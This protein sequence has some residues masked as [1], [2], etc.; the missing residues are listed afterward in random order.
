MSDKLSDIGTQYD[1]DS[2][3]DSSLS[4]FR[5]PDSKHDI[6]DSIE[7]AKGQDFHSTGDLYNPMCKPKWRPLTTSTSS[8]FSIPS[9]VLIPDTA[10]CE[11]AEENDGYDSESSADR[12]IITSS[13]LRRRRHKE[14][15]HRPPV[16]RLQSLDGEVYSPSL[17]SSDSEDNEKRFHSCNFCPKGYTVAK[18]H[19]TAKNIN[20]QPDSK[21]DK[22]TCLPFHPAYLDILAINASREPYVVNSLTTGGAKDRS[23]PSQASEEQRG[24]TTDIITAV[25]SEDKT[26][27]TPRDPSTT[28][29][30]PSSVTPGESEK[31]TVSAG[32]SRSASQKGKQLLRSNPSMGSRGDSYRQSSQET[33]MI[34]V[35]SVNSSGNLYFPKRT[36]GQTNNDSDSITSVKPQ[37]VERPSIDSNYLYQAEEDI[38]FFSIYKDI[39]VLQL[40]NKPVYAFKPGSK[41]LCVGDTASEDMNSDEVFPMRLGDAYIIVQMYGDMW[42]SCIKLSLTEDISCAYANDDLCGRRI[43]GAWITPASAVKFLPLCALTLQANFGDYLARHPRNTRETPRC[44]ATGQLVMPPPRT[45]SKRATQLVHDG[46]SVIVPLPIL[47]D[48]KRTILPEG[49]TWVPL[50]ESACKYIGHVTIPM[51]QN[52]TVMSND[53]ERAGRTTRFAMSIRKAVK[54]GSHSVD[55][56]T[57]IQRTHGSVRR[58]LHARTSTSVTADETEVVATTSAEATVAPETS[59]NVPAATAHSIRSTRG[60]R[61]WRDLF[62]RT[63][64]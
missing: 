3:T 7:I 21:I 49:K 10:S 2:D 39:R 48:C 56:T 35:A 19:S 37:K 45:V 44:P 50:D 60:N 58:H 30:S 52:H 27:S 36:Q 23:D 16:L 17:Y 1:S 59:T 63:E 8:G 43:K 33:S 51:P 9:N 41:V 5:T 40:A 12:Q 61:R 46:G 53:E 6:R 25:S 20:V 4:N 15:F 62:Y 13:S 34:D 18:H 57:I 28:A 38:K 32:A 31:K 64:G 22:A 24:E 54:R 55:G 14:Y 26:L 29:Q 47:N 42:A 11:D